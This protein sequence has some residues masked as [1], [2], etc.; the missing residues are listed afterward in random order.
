MERG[1]GEAGK[2]SLGSVVQR[3]EMNEGKVEGKE[4]GSLCTG[5][6]RGKEIKLKVDG[7]KGK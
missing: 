1:K 5:S 2:L 6:K 7:F 3:K 4:R